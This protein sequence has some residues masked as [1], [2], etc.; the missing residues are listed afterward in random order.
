MHRI[1]ASSSNAERKSHDEQYRERVRSLLE[2]RFHLNVHRETKESSVYDLVAGKNGPTLR[3]TQATNDS[4][5]SSSPGRTSGIGA[6][7]GMLAASLASI[8]GRP[9]VDKTGLTGKYDYELEWTPEPDT[10]RPDSPEPG[11]AGGI[12]IFTA[13][14]E[15][16]GLKLES[17]KGPVDTVVIDRIE[18]P[19]DN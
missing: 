5:T 6:T 9:V 17:A 8:T 3:E 7:I 18:R 16:L 13:L 12:A 2:D 11:P 14:Q 15:K 1:P 4:T 10:L 19:S